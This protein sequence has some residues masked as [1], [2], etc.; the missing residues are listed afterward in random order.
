MLHKITSALVAYGP[1]GVFVLGLIDSVGIPLPAT[2][3]L[4]I[5]VIA[6]HSP[7]RAYLAA[8]LGVIGSTIGNLVL[9]EMA[10]YGVSRLVR[11]AVQP[12]R[13]RTWF[14]RYGLVTVFIPAAVPVVPLPLK[15]FVVSAGVLRASPLHFLVIILLARTCRYFGD[16]F[17]GLTLGLNAQAF[18]QHNVWALLAA[19]VALAAALLLLFRWHERRRQLVH[20]RR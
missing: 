10:R 1:W 7:G 14:R 13:F 5:I 16:A 4:L 17:L 19:A 15:F 12:G 2:M 11:M 9:F 8:G 20:H 18:L 6:A 3:D